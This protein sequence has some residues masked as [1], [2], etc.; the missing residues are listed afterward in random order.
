MKL[1]VTRS[2]LLKVLAH[3][4][5]VVERRTTIPI[6]TN[7]KLTAEGARLTVYGTD[8][9]I[10]ATAAC[11]AEIAAPGATTVPAATLHDIVRKL[12]D[13]DIAIE[14]AGTGLQVRAGRSRFTLSVLAPEDFPD[15]G[16]GTYSHTFVIAGPAL[17]R[18]IEPAQ[19]AI[20]TEETR[21]YLNG[22]YLHEKAGPDGPMLRAVATDGH[23]LARIETAFPSGA[24]GMPGIIIPRK[25]VGEVVRLLKE[26][27]DTHGTVEVAVSAQK[28][29]FVI[30]GTTLT[31]K[32]IDGTFPDY[33][34]V[35]PTGNDKRLLIDTDALIAAVD[36]VAT[37]AGESGRAVRLQ[38][39]DGL[40]VLSMRDPNSGEATE[41]VEVDYDDAPFEIGFNAKYLAEMLSHTGGDT[42]LA[43]MAEA[44]AP[45]IF[46]SREDAPALFVLMPMRV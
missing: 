22:I 4:S 44:G 43:W 27:D 38:L 41:E 16:V 24:A 2:A 11:A 34:R 3:V 33:E 40:L 14:L 8:L 18:L 9:D 39:N 30:A 20:S 36:R 21:F 10:E 25:T 29:R 5:R 13:G 17:L 28:I 37:V 46:Q 15:L 6:L 42:T 31:S 35:I 26:H 1:T 23:R 12:P 32:L 19:F 45:T 7:L